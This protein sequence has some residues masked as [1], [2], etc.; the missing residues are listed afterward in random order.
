MGDWP[1]FREHW[2]QGGSIPLICRPTASEVTRVLAYPKFK[3]SNR[4]RA[5]LLGLYLPFCE[6]VESSG[7]CLQT[8]R[9]P[10]DQMFPDLAQ[11]GK[12]DILVSGDQDLL[13]LEIQT[14][15]SIK[16][17]ESYRSLIHP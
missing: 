3:L 1:G 13:A 11:S 5:E 9:D 10:H 7:K 4:D 15:F 12:A 2:K 14:S 17:P 16:S 8:C 6:I